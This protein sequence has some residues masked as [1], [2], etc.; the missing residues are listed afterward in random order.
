VVVV[1]ARRGVVG[2]GRLPGLGRGC[3]LGPRRVGE[4]RGWGVG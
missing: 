1:L 3:S 2:V 4:G